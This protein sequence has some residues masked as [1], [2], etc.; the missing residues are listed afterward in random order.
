MARRDNDMTGR[1]ASNLRWCGMGQIREGEGR[2]QRTRQMRPYEPTTDWGG[3]CRLHEKRGQE[4]TIRPNTQAQAQKALSHRSWSL[5]EVV[6]GEGDSPTTPTQ[7][8][9]RLLYQ[10]CRTARYATAAR[11]LIRGASEEAGREVRSTSPSVQ[12]GR[13][14][15]SLEIA[16]LQSVHLPASPPVPVYQSSDPARRQKPR[17]E[18]GN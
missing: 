8:L 6:T 15:S 1:R 11:Y 13:V 4:Q 7:N 3:A 12:Y 17:A 9:R 10:D 16:T 2:W 18:L 5:Q 14:P